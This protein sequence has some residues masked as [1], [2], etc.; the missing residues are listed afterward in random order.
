MWILA[1]LFLIAFCMLCSALFSGLETGIVS[2]HRLRLKH[3]ARMG[4]RSARMLERFLDSPDRLLG[5]VLVGTNICNVL[6]STATASLTIQLAGEWAQPIS[7]LIL[8]I[9]VLIL[10]EYLPKAWFHSKAL[11]RSQSFAGML[12]ISEILFLPIS[13]TVMAF[14]KLLTFGSEM[15]K[16]RH[17]DLFLTRDNLLHILRDS[18][19]RGELSSMERNMISRVMYLPRMKARDIMIPIDEVTCVKDTMPLCQFFETA[20]ETGFTRFPVRHGDNGTFSGVINVFFVLSHKGNSEAT[21]LGDFMSRPLKI[22]A[23]CPVDGILPRLRHFRQPMGLVTNAKEE[24]I[25]IVTTEDVL[26]EIVS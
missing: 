11:D 6:V 14:S 12:R 7:G 15:E 2:I 1:H 20:R 18:E 13:A 26:E 19:A 5:T 22:R 24:V 3:R 4:S 17:Q 21:S 25:G 10:C 23:D 8:G 9:T 16:Q